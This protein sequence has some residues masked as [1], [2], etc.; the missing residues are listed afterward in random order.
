[1]CVKRHVHKFV[2]PYPLH[3]TYRAMAQITLKAKSD[4]SNKSNSNGGEVTVMVLES[5]DDGV[6]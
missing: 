3:F 4:E 1:V 5:N 6:R 2:T